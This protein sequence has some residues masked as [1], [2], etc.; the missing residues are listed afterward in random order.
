MR[1]RGR[2]LTPEAPKIASK[3]LNS[4][5]DSTINTL[6]IQTG[7]WKENT[8]GREVANPQNTN[9]PTQILV[10]DK[11][12]D[13]IM[14]LIEKTSAQY[15]E[16]IQNELG[17]DTIQI[18]LKLEAHHHLKES[19]MTWSEYNFDHMPLMAILPLLRKIKNDDTESKA[20]IFKLMMNK[21]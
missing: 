8:N 9:I 12:G 10:T 11:L 13:T 14:Q 6:I 2:K 5:I 7:G 16:I 17:I 18:P 15:N 1:F 21:K 4:F 3:G 19:G 20:M